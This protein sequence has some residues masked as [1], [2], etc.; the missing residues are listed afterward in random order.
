MGKAR[1]R[2]NPTRS[3]CRPRRATLNTGALRTVAGA[4]CT[5]LIFQLGA[6]WFLFSPSS[7]AVCV[8]ACVSCRAAGLSA[9]L[10]CRLRSTLCSER[11]LSDAVIVASITASRAVRDQQTRGG[12][13]GQSHASRAVQRAMPDLHALARHPEPP[14]RLSSA[15]ADTGLSAQR[16]SV[17]RVTAVKRCP[18]RLL[19]PV[20][21]CCC[22]INL[23]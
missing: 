3:A 16:I 14:R 19:Q 23:P 2:A 17:R 8:A 15:A 21:L 12:Q 5:A 10:A 22:K 18:D 20:G 13:S 1:A 7:S 11:V 6:S 9:L 4:P